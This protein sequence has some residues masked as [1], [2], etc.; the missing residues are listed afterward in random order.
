MIIHQYIKRGSNHP[1]YCEDFLIVSK[2]NDYMLF[3]VFDG[4]SS[5]SDSH[6][7]SAL[8]GK[9][10]K[11][12]F[13]KMEIKRK[14][15]IEKNLKTLLF[16]SLMSLKKLKET[17]LLD[18]YEELLSTIILFLYDTTKNNGIIVVSGD[19][20]VSINGTE[21]IIDQNNAPRYP[22]YYLD[23]MYDRISFNTWYGSYN[24][25]FEVSELVDVS[26][27]TDGVL[28]FTGQKQTENE[29]KV[30]NVVDYLLKDD[31]LIANKA[32]SGRK[33]NILN[34]KYGLQNFDDLGL[35][36]IVKKPKK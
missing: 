31:F 20:L 26:I 5:G 24:K 17:L 35:I 2:K 16:N 7:A 27:S 23:E 9:I 33:V 1:D 29:E 4:C 32:M 36:R 19:G 25:T 18:E 15:K 10:I 22:A 6:F 11:A 13:L 14:D 12:E 21:T 34:K 30:I 8:I 28:S 3:G